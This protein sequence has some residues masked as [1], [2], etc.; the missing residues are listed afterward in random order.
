MTAIVHIAGKQLRVNDRMRQRC[1]W[2]GTVLADYDLKRTMVM[3][4]PGE[5]PASPAMWEE[6]AFVAVD[7]AA[8]WVE[9][10]PGGDRLPDEACALIDDDVTA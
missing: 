10:S 3:V 2:C 7:G 6:D 9:P 5:K 1:S 4:Q 8:S